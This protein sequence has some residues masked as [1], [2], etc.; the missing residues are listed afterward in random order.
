MPRLSRIVIP[1]VPHHITQRGNRKQDVFFTVDDRLTYLN[2]LYDYSDKYNIETLAYCLMDNHVH[3]IAVPSD[4]DSLE[5]M[6]RSLHSRYAQKIN[7]DHDW[8]GHLWQGRYFSSPLDESYLWAAIKYVETNP[9]RTGLV[10]HAADYMWSSARGHCGLSKDKLLSTR[11]QWTNMFDSIADWAE[12]LAVG[13]EN[14][15]ITTAIRTNTAKGMPSGTKEFLD[16]L[17]ILTKR[18][19]HPRSPGR[20]KL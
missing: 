6:L 1:G 12:W 10:S 5:M 3:L 9:V 4:T 16:K 18:S 11:M 8:T 2:W 19:V 20:P 15:E 14:E 13:Q 7:R 17:T